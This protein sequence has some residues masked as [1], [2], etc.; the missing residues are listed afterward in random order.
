M[1]PP[2]FRPPSPEPVL[3]MF[4][5]YV[6]GLG[7]FS[8]FRSL[9]FFDFPFGLLDN[10]LTLQVTEGHSVLQMKLQVQEKV[11]IALEQFDLLYN[12]VRLADHL[13]V[14]DY[15]LQPESSVYFSLRLR[16]GGGPLTISTE[17]LA[18]EF[19][20]D[21]T[22]A[23]DDGQ[24][25][26]R[27]GFEYKRP[28]GWKRFAVKALGRYENDEWLGPN[29]IRTSQARG[30]WPVSYHGTN[31]SSA[32]KIVKEGY[33]PGQRARFGKGIYTSPSLEMVERDYAQEFSYDGKTY[34]IAFQN[35]VNPDRNGHLTIISALDTGA[36]ADYWLSPKDNDD[37]RPYGL[38]LREVQQTMS[39]PG[40]QC[41]AFSPAPA[42]QSS[43][44]SPAKQT[45]G[46]C[47]LQWVH[48][49][50]GR[51]NQEKIEISALDMVPDFTTRLLS[52][53]K[54]IRLKDS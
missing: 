49:W 36:G 16:G 15:G 46:T 19:D 37:V 23:K 5:I 26:M 14:K 2:G 44:P 1:K 53:R 28:Y 20:Y 7:G 29:G 25:Y 3:E 21:Y 27:G 35:R 4:P 52:F 30:E 13:T 43:Q 8:P 50:C 41:N 22:D 17:G 18:P 10:A 47:S 39:Q 6:K 45:D 54:N 33:K 40:V 42:A 12:N 51:E 9:L 32:E 48:A 34:K 31:M 24:Q 11:G 38:L